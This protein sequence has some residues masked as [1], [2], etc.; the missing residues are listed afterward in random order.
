MLSERRGHLTRSDDSLMCK[1]PAMPGDDQSV[2]VNVSSDI[3]TLTS[4]L[5][6]LLFRI[7]RSSGHETLLLVREISCMRDL[8]TYGHLL[9]DF[10]ISIS[11]IH[12]REALSM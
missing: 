12:Q 10:N 2:L 9:V 5:E 11:I 8:S 7:L 3:I 4:S 6:R 1:H